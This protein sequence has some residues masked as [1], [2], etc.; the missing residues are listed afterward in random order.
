[1]S[2]EPVH[3]S[4]SSADA[5]VEAYLAKQKRGAKLGK[6]LIIAIIAIVGAAAIAV[7]VLFLRAQSEAEAE[8]ERKAALE[9]KKK[10]YGRHRAKI[11]ELRS[12]LKGS[13]CAKK[14]IVSLAERLNH[15]RAH[16]EALAESAAFFKRCGEHRRL[17]WATY[18]AYKRL[19]RDDEAIAE[20]TKLIN[21]VPRDRDYRWW[22]GIVYERKGDLARA[23]ED[24][25]Q[26][27]AIAPYLTRIPFNLAAVLERDHKPCE[28]RFWLVNYL[29]QGRRAVRQPTERLAERIKRLGA[30]PACQARRGRGDAIISL[31]E[32]ADAKVSAAVAI[33][34][35][36]VDTPFEVRP[37][38]V[39]SML[40]SAAAKAAGVA[41]DKGVAMIVGGPDGYLD[42]RRV[43]V[44]KVA[45]GGAE[46]RD[47]EFIVVNKL[48]RDA[49][50][51]LAQT[52]LGR[53]EVTK[54][55]QTRAMHLVGRAR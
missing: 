11:A 16:D 48:P 1:M 34:G 52:F 49:P 33:D 39:Y 21:A 6:P 24:Y 14:V 28:A 26:A 15:A 54:D 7:V 8:A 18:T 25:R 17:R 44:G 51:V 55:D 42:G 10:S 3:G 47:V 27:L 19:G 12:L 40:S 32:H 31:P 22:R 46:A 35:K 41:A 37:G 30:L 43:I 5:E 23:A 2:D 29:R 20:A 53:F 38:V 4:S 50:G 9:R 36:M 13:P 45:V